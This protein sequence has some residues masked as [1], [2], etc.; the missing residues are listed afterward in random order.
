MPLFK[1]PEIVFNNLINEI[2]NP[3][4]ID[5]LLSIHEEATNERR[6]FYVKEAIMD[7][8]DKTQLE[9]ETLLSDFRKGR[10]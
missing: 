6:K 2:A 7:V 1:D 3:W 5:E 4:N 8:T 10:K 9:V